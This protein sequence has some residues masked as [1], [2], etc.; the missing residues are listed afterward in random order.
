MKR[1][2]A[3]TLLGPGGFIVADAFL[4]PPYF[5]QCLFYGLIFILN[6]EFMGLGGVAYCR[7]GLTVLTFKLINIFI[8]C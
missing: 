6:T 4:F 2:T 7:G 1:R 5:T 8:V 3:V